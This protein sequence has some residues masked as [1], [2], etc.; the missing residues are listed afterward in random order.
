MCTGAAETTARYQKLTA[1]FK[2]AF[3][4]SPE[5]YARGSQVH[6]VHRSTP[7]Q[8]SIWLLL[9]TDNLPFC[10]GRVN[11]IGEHIDYEGYGVLLQMALKQV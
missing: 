4:H 10:A 3:G 9:L 11:L 2:Q 8:Q 1:A 7:W 5:V 6:A